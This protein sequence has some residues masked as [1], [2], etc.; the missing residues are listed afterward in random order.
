MSGSSGGTRWLTEDEQQV[1][2]S[3]LDV[4]RLLNVQLQRQLSRDSDLSLA[5]YEILVQ[6]SE[7][8]PRSMR[9]SELAE[10][11][12][13]SRSRLTHTVA[14]MESRGLVTRQ[15]CAD[16][17]RGVLCVLTDQGL[18]TL[19]AAAPGHVAEVRQA[20]FDA[21]TEQD[22]QALGQALGAVLERL[23]GM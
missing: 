7:T 15:P 12:V 13:H 1:W 5:E 9:M 2:R 14:R 18:A 11:A 23:R 10:R 22:V 16:D 21:L 4:S 19:V 3:W 8:P 6:L 20:I 17:G